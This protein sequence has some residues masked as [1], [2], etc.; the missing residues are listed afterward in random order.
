MYVYTV[1]MIPYMG[2]KSEISPSSFAKFHFRSNAKP[3]LC[4]HMQ[5]KSVAVKEESTP[6]KMEKPNFWPDFMKGKKGQ[7][8]V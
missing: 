4:C 6:L 7:N 8:V 5:R 2:M 3:L 1:Y